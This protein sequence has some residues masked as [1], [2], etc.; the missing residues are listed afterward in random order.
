MRRDPAELQQSL[1]DRLLAALESLGL[2]A[3]RKDPDTI[4]VNGHR[5]SIQTAASVGIHN[6]ADLAR[7]VGA[8][9]SPRLVAAE[10]I[11]EQARSLFR[12]AGVGFFDPRG[13]VRLTLPDLFLDTAV[14]SSPV[15]TSA[16]PAAL[17]GEVAKE[18]AIVLLGDPHTQHG[19][20][21]VAR[22]IGRAPST[23]SVAL[24]RLRGEGLVTSAS[25]PLV[26]ELFWELAA[27][28]RHGA[29]PLAGFPR[30][31]EG[32]TNARLQL[33]LGRGADGE[34]WHLDP[35]GWA[36][37]DTVAAS[38]WGMPVV[39]SSAYPPDFYVPSRL[40][41]DRA[42][43]LL[44]PSE[45]VADRKCTVAVPPAGIACRSRVNRPSTEWPTAPW[46]VVALDL[47][48]DRAR[49]R[50]ILERWTPPEGIERAW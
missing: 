1:A 14:S 37:T 20:R 13:H 5:V 21:E 43:A 47:A 12:E 49:G 10:R 17:A 33:G 31:G 29:V 2:R 32:S 36:L 4:V 8:P 41:L 30:P 22:R 24:D 11:T 48:Q 25:E 23:V 39:A 6:A 45:S 19:V 18:I 7:R 27:A 34:P 50:E 46:V 35:V 38:A 9:G 42:V 44:G 40:V 15:P 28:W 26:P 16:N 3:G